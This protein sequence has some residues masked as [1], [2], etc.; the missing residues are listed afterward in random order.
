MRTGENIWKRKDGRFEGRYITARDINGKA[1]YKSVY[2][3]T[4]EEVRKKVREGKRGLGVSG[5][6]W[7]GKSFRDAAE[8]WLEAKKGT[9][10]E[11][12]Y[13]IYRRA[14]SGT[15]YPE[16]GETPLSR[17]SD[18][19]VEHYAKAVVER[20]KEAGKR[21][22]Q[23]MVR[24]SAGLMAQVLEFA[25][26]E[27]GEGGVPD[28]RIGK[29]PYDSL[30][31]KEMVRVC[32]C[33]KENE[34]PEMLAVL[35]C[36]F[37]GLRI[38]EACALHW[39]DMDLETREI[40]VHA[41][42][43]RVSLSEEGEKKTELK[44]MEIPR[45]T[46]IRRVKIPEELA[47]YARKFYKE[48]AYALSGMKERATD[49]RVLMRKTERLFRDARIKGVNFQRLHKTYAEG[50]A[51]ESVLKDVFLG[52]EAS[53]P[54]RGV[55]D[56]EWLKSEM[57]LD[58]APLRILAGLSEGEM[59]EILEMPEKQYRSLERGS[60]RLAWEEYLA[61]L[62]MFHLNERTE[63]VVDSLGLY[64][65]ALRDAMKLRVKANGRPMGR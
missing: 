16:Y 12:T 53:R 15:V 34:S 36:L 30:T 14:L 45:K 44:V 58:L 49:S 20:A 6:A 4:K 48:G 46:Q 17:I 2:G 65:E 25:R 19:E 26:G 9:V 57:V 11:T 61:L 22:T 8:L 18:A 5:D 1:V 27:N 54:C 37:G 40:R 38:G 10:A 51:D 29:N 39:D 52:R 63:A 62:F 24:L 31:S 33:A 21:P 13:D 64:P 60:R 23:S 7:E 56:K 35:L 42:A 50:K 3:K 43:Q 41:T 47:R 32:R 59:G 28:A 55:L